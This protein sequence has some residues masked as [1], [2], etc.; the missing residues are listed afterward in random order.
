MNVLQEM[1][2]MSDYALPRDSVMCKRSHHLTVKY[3]LQTKCN[4]LS[5]YYNFVLL[6]ESVFLELRL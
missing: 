6:K 1:S 3:S 2:H 5:M 4:L